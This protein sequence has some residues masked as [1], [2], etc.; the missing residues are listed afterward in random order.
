MNNKIIEQIIHNVEKELEV[1]KNLNDIEQIRIQFLGKSS[2]I[3]K[4]IQQLPKKSISER[5]ILGNIV[6]LAKERI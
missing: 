3:F 6:N 1:S 5:P 4:I 2:Q